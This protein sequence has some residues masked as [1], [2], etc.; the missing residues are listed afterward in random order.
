M[1]ILIIEDDKKT[2]SYL[3]KG[4]TSSG[5]IVDTASDGIEGQHYV[6]HCQ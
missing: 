2:T 4:L 6:S 3:Y 5:Y 1:R